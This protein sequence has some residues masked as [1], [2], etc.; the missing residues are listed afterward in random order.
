MNGDLYRA[1]FSNRL[2]GEAAA[3]ISVTAAAKL[4][5]DAPVVIEGTRANQKLANA[6]TIHPF[7]KVILLERGNGA[8]LQ[9]IQVALSNPL[10]GTLTGLGAGNY[11]TATGLYTLADATLAQAQAAI[12]ALV[13]VPTPGQASPSQPVTTTFTLSAT[14]VGGTTTDDNTSTIVS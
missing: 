8:E 9:T 2:V 13:F 4:T 7:A 6:A 1:V 5:V 3:S 14:D 12:R 10:D 11:D